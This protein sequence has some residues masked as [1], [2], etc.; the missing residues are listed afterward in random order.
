M[1][2]TP[3]AEASTSIT[4]PARSG[5]SK[6]PARRGSWRHTKSSIE[7]IPLTKYI[8]ATLFTLVTAGICAG[9]SQPDSLGEVARRNN[10]NKKAVLVVTEDKIS[11]LGG[12]VSGVG[13]QMP[14]SSPHRAPAPPRK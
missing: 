8:A 11:S 13:L 10:H 1:L 14:Q 5:N 3:L 4:I 6:Y 7:G 2:R 9:Q 12:P